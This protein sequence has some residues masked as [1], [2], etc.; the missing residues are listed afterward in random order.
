MFL[1]SDSDSSRD[2]SEGTWIRH[3]PQINVN[4]G[5]I[6]SN[7]N[8]IIKK[9]SLRCL[10]CHIVNFT[11]LIYDNT[12]DVLLPRELLVR[13]HDCHR[14]HRK[15]ILTHGHQHGRQNIFPCTALMMRNFKGMASMVFPE[16]W[17]VHPSWRRIW[18]WRRRRRRRNRTKNSKF[19]G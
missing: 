15:V 4:Y 7:R 12:N 17:N 13:Q 3:L 19:P 18:A 1:V 16:S 14:G 5:V 8:V 10:L 2:G 11:C 9:T 6:W